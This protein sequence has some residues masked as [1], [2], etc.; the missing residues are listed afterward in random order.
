MRNKPATT[1]VPGLARGR[2]RL[3]AKQL[4]LA[5]AASLLL[6]GCARY[7]IRL[8]DG[9]TFI[10][11]RKPVYNKDA[12]QYV[13]KNATGKSF[14]VNK[15]KVSVMEPHQSTKERMKDGSFYLN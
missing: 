11:V 5:L 14:T 13:I 6:A 1:K 2:L 8:T 15:S 10:N 7:D 12:D 9:R 4:T 3:V